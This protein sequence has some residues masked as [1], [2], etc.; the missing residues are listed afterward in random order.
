MPLTPGSTPPAAGVCGA[1]LEQARVCD[2]VPAVTTNCCVR[3]D[4]AT[5]ATIE[6]FPADDP[7]VTV[8]LAWPVASVDAVPGVTVAAPD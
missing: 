6:T 7:S 1:L 2:V 4:P 3:L 5:A 8:A